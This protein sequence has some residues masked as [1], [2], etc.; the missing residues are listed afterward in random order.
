MICDEG[1]VILEISVFPMGNPLPR[2]MQWW[3]VVWRLSPSVLD[4]VLKNFPY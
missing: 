3:F 4:E 1:V 2:G